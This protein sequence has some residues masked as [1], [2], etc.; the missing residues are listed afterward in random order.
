[1]FVKKF[2]VGTRH[3]AQITDVKYSTINIIAARR[4]STTREV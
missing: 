1:M 4:A 3:V 2:L